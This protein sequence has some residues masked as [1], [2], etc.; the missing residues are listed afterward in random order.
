MGQKQAKKLRKELRQQAQQAEPKPKA[1]TLAYPKSWQ[2]DPNITAIWAAVFRVLFVPREEFASGD[3]EIELSGL[4]V[5]FRYDTLQY[6]K[7]HIEM[8]Y[9]SELPKTRTSQSPLQET[10][11]GVYAIIL[12]SVSQ[13][14]IDGDR[15]TI[16][17]K[18]S[19]VTGLI[20]SILG[21]NAVY[22]R[23]F[24]HIYNLNGSDIGVSEPI[25]FTMT[26]VD[27]SSIRLA[28]LLRIDRAIDALPEGEQNRV[29]LS[30]RWFD[31]ANNSKGIDTYLNFWFALETLGMPDT[32][33]IRPIN[34]ALSRAYNISIEDVRNKFAVGRL[35]D[36]R[37]SIVHNGV[38]VALSANLLNYISALYTDLLYERLGFESE[39]RA[40]QVMNQLNF[41]VT[42]YLR[43][44]HRK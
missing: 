21:K 22:E 16:H 26:T 11:V 28:L 3:K 32:S 42:D 15:S 6:K 43:N 10:S 12:V 38:I 14:D 2:D 37:A 7:Y 4:K 30:L 9:A 40:S 39:Q 5:I 35:Q 23:V 17:A 33:N 36:L 1:F 27:M 31:K 8:E 29:R 13:E 18:I 20:A 44:L 19:V 25:T 34:E 41:S 24:D